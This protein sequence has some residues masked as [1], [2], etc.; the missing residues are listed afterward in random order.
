MDKIPIIENE[1]VLLE[2]FVKKSEY[3]ISRYA[4]L[5]PSNGKGRWG[6]GK[7][8]NNQMEN[9]GAVG[10]GARNLSGADE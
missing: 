7:E 4:M 10:S 1:S 2:S 3:S 9:A 5:F 6:S 8:T